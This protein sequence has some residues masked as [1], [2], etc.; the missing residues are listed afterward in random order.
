MDIGI[1]NITL[2]PGTAQQ[3]IYGRHLQHFDIPMVVC[4]EDAVLDFLNGK[5]FRRRL[6]TGRTKLPAF[7]MVGF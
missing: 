6:N 2:F 3:K 5:V 1:Q 4:V 7:W